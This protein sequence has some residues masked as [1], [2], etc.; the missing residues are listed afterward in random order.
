MWQTG[1]VANIKSSQ[2]TEDF[3]SFLSVFFPLPTCLCL[4]IQ[5]VYP[6]DVKLTEKEVVLTIPLLCLVDSVWSH[7]DSAFLLVNRRAAFATCLSQIPT[8]VSLGELLLPSSLTVC[9]SNIMPL[10]F[11]GC[12]GDTQFTF[13][14]RQSVGR[15]VTRR[16][17]E[18]Y[19]RDAPVTLQ[20]SVKLLLP[21]SS[22]APFW[23]TWSISHG[24]SL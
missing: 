16:Q 1:S 6:Q 23:G 7:A 5:L 24:L 15:R 19:N 2:K 14:L 13:R 11:L 21:G 8:Q 17:E 10:C 22:E 18:V 9:F 12:L 20:V 4:F 3:K